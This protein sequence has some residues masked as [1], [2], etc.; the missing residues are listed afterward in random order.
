MTKHWVETR[1]NVETVN[2]RG[3]PVTITGV[4]ALLD[5]ESGMTR[6]HPYALAQ[7]EIENLAERFS[8][9]PRDI[10]TMLILYAKP[11]HFKGGEVLFKYHLQK[12]LFY[13]WKELGNYGYYESMPRDEYIAAKNGPK[14]SGI[15]EDLTRFL[16]N[17]LITIR[18]EFWDPEAEGPSKR[19]ILTEKGYSLAEEIWNEVPIPYRKTAIEVKTRI[20]PMEPTKVRHLVHMEYPEYRDTYVENDVE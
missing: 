5:K 6:I 7:A 20:H 3:M 15:D 11:G 13:L 16:D 14:P 18:E 9:E 4:K 8:I 1:I 17:E 2:W 12:M 10:A 19:I